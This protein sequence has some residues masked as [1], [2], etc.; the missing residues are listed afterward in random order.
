MLILPSR[1]E[2]DQLITLDPVSSLLG[3]MTSEPSG[4]RSTLARKPILRT[5]PQV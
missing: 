3:T 1:S 5:S 4:V 2:S